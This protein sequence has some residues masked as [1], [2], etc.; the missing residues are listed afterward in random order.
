MRVVGYGR[1]YAAWG[2]VWGDTTAHSTF[3]PVCRES[4]FWSQQHCGRAHVRMDPR[5]CAPLV[6]PDH[7]G[8][9]PQ[10]HDTN[11]PWAQF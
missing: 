10:P 11:G 1:G 5:I 4:Y 3:E 9:R 8:V 6:F 2:H 7:K